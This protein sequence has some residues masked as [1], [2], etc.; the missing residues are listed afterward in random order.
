MSLDPGQARRVVELMALTAVVDGEADPDEATLVR[1]LVETEP[2]L[3]GVP[4]PGGAIDEARDRAMEIGVE[5]CIREV[6]AGVDAAHR[7]L[8]FSCCG[9]VVCADSEIDDA[10]LAVLTT[11]R[12]AF[13]L[14]MDDARRLL[15]WS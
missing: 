13:G 4:D 7:E 12:E 11:L 1:H 8:A 2:A 9:R 6:A 3:A 14:S 15:S 5:A 10:E